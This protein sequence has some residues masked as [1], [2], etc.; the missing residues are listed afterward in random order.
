MSSFQKTFVVLGGLLNCCL[1]E[2]PNFP[3]EHFEV[4]TL[5]DAGGL[6]ERQGV[7]ITVES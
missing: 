7:L 3:K 2:T 5:L 4:S 6:C 1:R